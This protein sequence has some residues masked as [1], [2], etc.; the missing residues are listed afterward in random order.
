MDPRRALPA[1]KEQPVPELFDPSQPPAMPG[2]DH[3]VLVF[4]RGVIE[5]FM[6]ADERGDGDARKLKAD[7]DAL[8]ARQSGPP[9]TLG[10]TP[11]AQAQQL[12]SGAWEAGEEGDLI[13]LGA[14][15]LWPNCCE[16][17]LLL[18]MD[19]AEEPELTVILYT[20]AVMAGAEALG[21]EKLALLAGAFSEHE[22]TLPFL[23]AMA[24]LARANMAAGAPDAAAM[25]LGEILR[26]DSADLLGARY[27]L[28][29]L[30]LAAGDGDNAEILIDAYN[31]PSAP[32]L[33]G[34]VLIA[35]Q[36]KSDGPAVTARL[37]MA[38]TVNPYVIPYLTG[39]KQITSAGP[40]E[41]EFGSEAEAEAFAPLILG[42]W[43]ATEGAIEWLQRTTGYVP[44][45]AAKAPEKA[46]R[47]GPRE[48]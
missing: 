30:L 29:A 6:A 38:K 11:Q 40:M 3:P 9:R 10:M 12:M 27:E 24:G 4:V 39:E 43:R 41:F 44:P 14:L 35:F 37:Q 22:E 21:P 36:R 48:V 1:T 16:A 8:L 7:V 5:I 19:A 34:T 33:F 45:V 32:M 25:H 17:Y 42:A 18:A 28:L 46:K 20:L 13:A 31:E 26:L 2:D 23:Q 15:H 47:S